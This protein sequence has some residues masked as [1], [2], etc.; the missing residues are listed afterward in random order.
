MF[1]RPMFDLKKNC[2][3]NRS[4]SER[5]TSKLTKTDQLGEIYAFNWDHN[6]SN[7]TRIPLFEANS[8]VRT[9]RWRLP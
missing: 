2:K 7:P 8:E 6:Y 1:F 3:I 5:E 4:Y 9:S